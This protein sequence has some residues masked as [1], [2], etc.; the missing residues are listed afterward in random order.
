MRWNSHYV[1]DSIGKPVKTCTSVNKSINCQRD[2]NPIR[3]V[4]QLETIRSLIDI[5]VLE[6]EQFS[7]P[8]EYTNG[9]NL[10]VSSCVMITMNSAREKRISSHRH[11]NIPMDTTHSGIPMC[12]EQIINIFIGA[13][14]CLML[15]YICIPYL[16]IL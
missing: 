1:D 10:S 9:H 14:Q 15:G 13:K 4:I 16:S 5:A 7:L 2:G 8:L 12:N 11:Q 6:R 3:S